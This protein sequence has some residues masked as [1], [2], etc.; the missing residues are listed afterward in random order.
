VTDRFRQLPTFV[1]QAR[2]AA[3][4]LK[5]SDVEADGEPKSYELMP[6][7]F[8]AAR[9]WPLRSSIYVD[10]AMAFPALHAG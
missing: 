10:R 3:D 8:D 4:S 1:R 2:R 5:P 7:L 6:G 9:A